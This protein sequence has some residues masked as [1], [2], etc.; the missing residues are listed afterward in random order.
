MRQLTLI[1]AKWTY[2]LKTQTPDYA[3]TLL[4][5]MQ[6]HINAK[7]TVDFQ[8]IIHNRKISTLWDTGVSKS[9]IS[10]NCL[11]KIHCT[12]KVHP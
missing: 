6:I 12:D 2:L 4:K 11:Q 5:M 9:V 3:K 7:M 10:E 8:V 1:L